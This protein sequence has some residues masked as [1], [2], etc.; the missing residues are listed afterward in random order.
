MQGEYHAL[1][2]VLCDVSMPTKLCTARCSLFSVAA[3]ES[4]FVLLQLVIVWLGQP[5]SC[6]C[7]LVLYF[8]GL[9]ARAEDRLRAHPNS[10]PPFHVA[11]NCNVQDGGISI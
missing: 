8:T 1:I 10:H 4:S 5:A 11:Y 9:Y 6:W 2:C 3:F 7:V